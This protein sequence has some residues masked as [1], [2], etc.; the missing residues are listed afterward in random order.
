VPMGK[1]T[2]RFIRLSSISQT[3]DTPVGMIADGHQTRV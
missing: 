2:F 3:G 1:I